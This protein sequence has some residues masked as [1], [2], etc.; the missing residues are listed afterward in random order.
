MMGCAQTKAIRF[1]GRVECHESHCLSS[2]QFSRASKLPVTSKQQLAQFW[3]TS[4]HEPLASCFQNDWTNDSTQLCMLLFLFLKKKQKNTRLQAWS[5]KRTFH[6]ANMWMTK[7]YPLHW[8][9]SK[10]IENKMVRAPLIRQLTRG[11][12]FLFLSV[13]CYMITWF[14]STQ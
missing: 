3:K 13:F 9:E 12:S 6:M 10:R 11:P 8:K 4:K 5:S 2:G 14:R 1:V 7:T